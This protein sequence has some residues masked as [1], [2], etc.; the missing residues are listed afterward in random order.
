[1]SAEEKQDAL[2]LLKSPDI[3]QRISDD[4]EICGVVGESANLAVAYLATISRKLA[5]PLAVLIQSTSAAGKSA[6]MDA[7]LAFIPEEEQVSY[8]A[9]TG[10][11]LFYLGETA[12]KRKV[13]AIAEEEGARDAGYALKLLQSQG[14]L[15]IASTGKDPVTGKLVT[16][17]YRVEGPVALRAKS[18]RGPSMSGSASRKRSKA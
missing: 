1:M 4:A 7:V 14:D 8:A 12:L 10:Q 9:M 2:S 18:R 3:L 17:D 11:A 5:K 15:S 16:Q 13:L 6:L